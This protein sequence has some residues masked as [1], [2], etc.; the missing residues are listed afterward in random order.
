M[1][2]MPS[3]VSVSDT[4]CLGKPGSEAVVVFHAVKPGAVPSAS[5]R[6]K[7]LKS[8]FCAWPR[9]GNGQQ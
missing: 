5:L 7:K 3:M 9:K 8:I 2:L 4:I 6:P 1:N